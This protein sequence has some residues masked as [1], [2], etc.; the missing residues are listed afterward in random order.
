MFTELL[1]YVLKTILI[2]TYRTTIFSELVTQNCYIEILSDKIFSPWAVKSH[3]FKIMMVQASEDLYGI[4]AHLC[5]SYIFA[6]VCIVKLIVKLDGTYTG[7]FPCWRWCYLQ[8]Y[9]QLRPYVQTWHF[10]L[11]F[12]NSVS[13]CECKLYAVALL[14]L[15][16]FSLW[17][18]ETFCLSTDQSELDL[19]IKINVFKLMV[20]IC[21]H[22]CDK[23]SWIS[24]IQIFPSCLF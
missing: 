4:Y 12:L 7:M 8:C 11:F 9:R 1:L 24:S 5:I 3:C 20:E 21:I 19:E 16:C 15:R 13:L 2:E 23:N 17:N 10:L 6:Y 22:L 14:S 18:T